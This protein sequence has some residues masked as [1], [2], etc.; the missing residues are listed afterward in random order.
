MKPLAAC[1]V[2]ALAVSALA[3]CK[4]KED[5]Q[6]P[7]ATATFSS[8][9]AKAPLGSPLDLTYRFVV[10]ANAPAF[11][12]EY[13]VLVHFLDSDDQLMWTD[14]HFPP[15]S[16][17]E[18]KP[19]QRI[20]YSRTM[21]VPQYPYMGQ[22]TIRIGLYDPESGVRLPLGGENDG[23]RAYK[24][25]T[26]ELLPASDNVFIQFKDG[27]HNAEVA[28]ENAQVEWQWTKK[29]ATLA[30][31]NPR[32]DATFFLHFDGRP[33]LV[34]GQTVTRPHRRP[35]ARHLHA[36]DQ[37]RSHP[38]RAH[39]R[40]AVRRRR[41]RGPHHRGESGVRAGADAG[42][43]VVGPA[44]VGY[45]RVPRLHRAEVGA[46]RCRAGPRPSTCRPS[47]ARAAAAVPG[48][49]LLHWR[50]V[51]L[52]PFAAL[53]LGGLVLLLPGRA[54]AE[55]VTLTTGRTLSV[56]SVR[57]DGE[58]AVLALRGGGEVE[59][60]VALLKA[61][62]PDEVPYPEP[63]DVTAERQRPRRRGSV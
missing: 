51:L 20:E 27:W 7:V 40:D 4:K 45:P 23:Q 38:P 41:E 60:N 12:K 25:G 29:V 19:G 6:P 53:A 46:G 63:E 31:R 13:R 33:D 16:T 37:R 14:D 36:D 55:L 15:I 43:Q 62:A 21:F 49:S 35:G 48:E 32:R 47:A 57:I 44:R 30:L 11:D 50:P 56:R 26:L 42:R 39:R 9:R 2:V 5:T 59:C 8:S 52:R 24:A 17:K 54:S 10:A 61:V 18:W 1:V 28:A 22:A 34:P 58:T 3:G